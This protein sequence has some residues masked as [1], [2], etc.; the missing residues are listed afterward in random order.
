[1]N[2]L[3]RTYIWIRIVVHFEVST[4]WEGRIARA[5]KELSSFDILRR[6]FLRGKAGG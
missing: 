4:V 6:G 1:M 3:S 5:V 2:L